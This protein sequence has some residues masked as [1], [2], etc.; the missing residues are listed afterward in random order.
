MFTPYLEGPGPMWRSYLD[1]L[2]NWT[3]ADPERCA[4]VVT[5]ATGTFEALERWLVPIDTED[6]A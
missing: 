2:E 4:G 5:A 6:A 1:V 3:G